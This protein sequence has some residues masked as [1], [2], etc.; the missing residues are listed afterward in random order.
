MSYT[1]CFYKKLT[2]DN[3]LYTVCTF[4]I[5]SWL[6]IYIHNAKAQIKRFNAFTY[7]THLNMPASV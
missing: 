2:S 7:D 3:K 4:Q 6:K 1:E 5:A